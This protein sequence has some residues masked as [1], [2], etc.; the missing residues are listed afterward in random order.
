MLW[1]SPKPI[2]VRDDP[3]MNPCMKVL[4]I[5]SG[6][7]ITYMSKYLPFMV[8]RMRVQITERLTKSKAVNTIAY[9]IMHADSEFPRTIVELQ[10]LCT[11]Y[12]IT[13]TEIIHYDHSHR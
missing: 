9:L 8:G 4:K 6:V 7:I 11:A 12:I 3:G 10:L 13:D 2:E 1:S 5:F